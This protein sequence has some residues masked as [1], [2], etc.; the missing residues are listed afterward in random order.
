MKFQTTRSLPL[1][2]ITSNDIKIHLATTLGLK[3]FSYYL[4]NTRLPE[5]SSSFI[6]GADI[7]KASRSI[8]EGTLH[9]VPV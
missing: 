9:L 3:V 2:I 4:V 8:P 6:D 1:L 7:V 5:V